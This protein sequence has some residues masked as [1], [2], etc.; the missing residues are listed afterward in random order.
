MSSARSDGARKSM[1]AI[2]LTQ[3]Q[4]KH[5]KPKDK[6][7]QHAQRKQGKPEVK[8]AQR[9]Q[10]KPE[11]KP[12]SKVIQPIQRKQSKPSKPEVK[13]TQPQRVPAASPQ[14]ESAR[15]QRGGRPARIAP[16]PLA[17]PSAGP[18]ATPDVRPSAPLDLNAESD[19]SRVSAPLMALAKKA[20]SLVT[21][22]A[23]PRAETHSM[24][25]TP[26]SETSEPLAAEVADA[27]RRVRVRVRRKR[28]GAAP[29]AAAPE[30]DMQLAETS[31]LPDARVVPPSAQPSAPSQA[32]FLS[33]TALLSA[34]AAGASPAMAQEEP[35]VTIDAPNLPSTPEGEVAPVAETE[36]VAGTTAVEEVAPGPAPAEPAEAAPA[37]P[38]KPATTRKL[39][40]L[41]VMAALATRAEARAESGALQDLEMDAPVASEAVG[42]PAADEP[43]ASSEREAISDLAPHT[44]EMTEAATQ[45][46]EKPEKPTTTPSPEPGGASVTRP[47]G[48]RGARA[49]QPAETAGSAPIAP[50][51]PSGSGRR[52]MWWLG[53]PQEA[54]GSGDGLDGHDERDGLTGHNGHNGHNGRNGHAELDESARHAEPANGQAA[55]SVETMRSPI[56]PPIT[57]MT[58]VTPVTPVTQPR[59]RPLAPPIALPPAPRISPSIPR[60]P[61]Y[62]REAARGLSRPRHA[63]PSDARARARE[64]ERDAHAP[65]LVWTGGAQAAL[66][67][68]AALVAAL[69]LLNGSAGERARVVFA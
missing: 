14:M 54:G 57:P 64:Q 41:A 28:P 48:P 65:L 35:A 39:P 12:D 67:G 11:A 18:S 20:L 68:V 66:C 33:D 44:G 38:R 22:S 29:P 27:P 1:R 24:V 10:S 4:R 30:R 37:E 25:M 7:S 45:A 26:T 6:A 58:P 21:R 36:T 56:A 63:G 15:G 55:R 2:P 53:R 52:R 16:A 3:R 49:S 5:G 31:I 9:A 59:L 40:T 23:P 60:Q 43:P 62:R 50:E 51:E 47:R 69:A 19:A 34:D 17:T 46:P 32:R 42:A 61:D 8:V 13:A